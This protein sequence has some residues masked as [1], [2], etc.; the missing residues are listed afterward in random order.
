MMMLNLSHQKNYRCLDE[1]SNV[2]IQ[3]FL[4]NGYICKTQWDYNYDSYQNRMTTYGD[5]RFQKDNI[6]LKVIWM[7]FDEDMR[8]YCDRLIS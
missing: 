3:V 5:M 1:P 7:H 4:V 8:N 6:K 2:K